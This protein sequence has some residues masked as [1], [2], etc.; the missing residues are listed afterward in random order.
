MLQLMKSV[1]MFKHLKVQ[2][3]LGVKVISHGGPVTITGSGVVGIKTT[4]ASTGGVD[5]SSAKDFT[6]TAGGAYHL[7]FWRR[8]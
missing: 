8:N 7:K 1:D 5:I 2:N 4:D 6:N 3:L